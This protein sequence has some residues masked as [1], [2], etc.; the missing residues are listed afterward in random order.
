MALE[1]FDQED[2]GK[3]LL[4]LEFFLEAASAKDLSS[5]LSSWVKPAYEA[6]V[7]RALEAMALKGISDTDNQRE[8]LD[9]WREEMERQIEEGRVVVQRLGYDPVSIGSEYHKGHLYYPIKTLIQQTT[10][11]LN[12]VV[13]N[14]ES[15]D[16]VVVRSDRTILQVKESVDQRG[17]PSGIIRL[18]DGTLLQKRPTASPETTWSWD[19]VQD[20][21]HLK[22]N[23]HHISTLAMRINR[24]LQKTVW[25]PEECDY[26]LLTCTAICS[27]VQAIFEAVPLI[28]LKGSHGTGKS[29]LGS[30]L[31]DVSCNAV[32][33]GKVSPDTM[34]RLIDGTRGLVVIDDL[35]GVG[36]KDLSS[37]KEK[38][39]EMIQALKQSYKKSSANKIITNSRKQTETLNFFGVKVISNT[40]GVDM[41]LGS[42]MLFV[43]TKNIP[44][45][46][47]P[48]FLGREGLTSAELETLR[49]D[50]HIW[51]FD[52]AEKVHEA[53]LEEVKGSSDRENEIAAPL[54][55]LARM[56]A[57]PEVMEA[58]ES[59]LARQS[60]RKRSYDNM[61]EAIE[62]VMDAFISE[63]RAEVS[64]I[65]V[66]LALR[67]AMHDRLKRKEWDIRPEKIS[68]RIR[69][70]GYVEGDG[71]RM[72]HFGYQM[73]VVQLSN[74]KKLELGV[75][76]RS[77]IG[78]TGF[79]QGCKRCPYKD[80]ACE[81][82]PSRMKAEG[83]LC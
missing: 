16:V 77:Q 50:L 22:Y 34:M 65:E 21:V 52:N 60:A 38:F 5:S 25:L 64:I 20:Y 4:A 71:R 75:T 24:H 18:E 69:S 51:A 82:R 47:I 61:D 66:S 41:I 26:W 12:G 11:D 83:I 37:G 54:R 63:G 15:L 9:T 32:I 57:V 76:E 39:T 80:L 2:A 8:L 1:L 33:V 35:E 70:L 28:L 44:G 81:I 74:A 55:A 40:R 31:R 49:H 72:T 19:S 53:Y 42:R 14:A 36:G 10:Y 67:A 73:R 79:C 56:I 29:Q 48:E 43:L 45:D 30:A 3:A 17:R 62:G 6:V 13:S 46:E 78:V 58:V 59:S 27:Y 23:T 68:K 7:S